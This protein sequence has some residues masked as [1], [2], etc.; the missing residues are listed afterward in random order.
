MKHTATVTDMEAAMY[1]VKVGDREWGPRLVPLLK[2]KGVPEY[3]L[4]LGYPVFHVKREGDVTTFEF[5]D[6][7]DHQPEVNRLTA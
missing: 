3:K 6:L 1:D 7:S 4:V 5:G 2:A